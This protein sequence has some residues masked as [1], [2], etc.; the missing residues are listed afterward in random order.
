LNARNLRRTKRVSVSN[1]SALASL[2]YGTDMLAVAP[3]RMGQQLLSRAA[4]V[5]LPFD[6]KPFTLLMIWHQRYQNDA[7]HRWLRNQI[8]AVAATMNGMAQ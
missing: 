5:P 1:F 3:E 8:N 4:W 2:L 6:Y 7:A